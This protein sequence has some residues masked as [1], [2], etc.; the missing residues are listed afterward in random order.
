MLCDLQKA[1]DTVG[2]KFVEVKSDLEDFIGADPVIGYYFAPGPSP[3][4][5][6]LVLDVFVLTDQCLYNHEISRETNQYTKACYMLLLN[7]ITELREKPERK[8]EEEFIALHFDQSGGSG[9]VLFDKPIRGEDIRKF[10]LKTRDAIIN[11]Q[12]S[13]K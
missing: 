10:C 13:T 4:M 6:T 3:M 7:H 11:R 2:L 8:N 9:L 1:C 5:P 12:R